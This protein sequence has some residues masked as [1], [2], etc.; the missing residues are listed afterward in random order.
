MI[1]YF[2]AVFFTA[3][4][5]LKYNDSERYREVLEN[6]YL[7]NKNEYNLIAII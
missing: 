2:A 6:K 5:A 3:D 7:N 1:S 4:D